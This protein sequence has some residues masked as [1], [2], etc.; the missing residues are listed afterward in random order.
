MKQFLKV[1]SIA[2]ICF[3][4]A[5]GAGVFTYFKFYDTSTADAQ[6]VEEPSNN[7]NDEE[8]DSGKNDKELTPFEKAVKESERINVLLL[9]LEEVRTDT[10]VF[11]SYDPIT[12]KA[13]LISIP[14]DTYY[15]RAGYDQPDKRKINAVYGDAGAKGVTRVVSHILGVPIHHYVLVTYE[16]VEEIVNALGGVEV[17]VP[18]HMKYEDPTDDPPLYIDI[19]AGKQILKGEKAVHFLRYRHGYPDGDLGRIKAQQQFMKSAAKKAL[20]IRL[21][22]V[23]NAVFKNVETDMSLQE[24]LSYVLKLKGFSMDNISMRTLPGRPIN[25]FG[26]SYFAHDPKQVKGLMKDIYGVKED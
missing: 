6:S 2:F 5:I 21:P 19:P 8:N 20:S 15:H 23:A 4:L 10:I 7:K 22:Y 16:G 3:A 26:L 9:G 12:K 13:N 18:F 17:D 11:A 1:F 25:K 24:M 14:R